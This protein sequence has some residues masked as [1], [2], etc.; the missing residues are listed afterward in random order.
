MKRFLHD[1]FNI[2]TSM[3][4]ISRVLKVRNLTKER[5]RGIA[6][7][8]RGFFESQVTQQLQPDPSIVQVQWQQSPSTSIQPVPDEEKV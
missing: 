2:D 3:A 1:R 7:Q 5:L 8:R 4:T 6:E